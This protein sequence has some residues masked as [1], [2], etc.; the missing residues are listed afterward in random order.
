[1]ATAKIS[2]TLD[3]SLLAEAR[4]LVGP[5]GLS[6]YLNQALRLQLQHHRLRGL[7]DE[8]E[9]EHGPI[10]PGVMEEV[11]Q[12]WPDPERPGHHGS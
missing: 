9:K 3:E 8:L 12:T 10:D 7:L 6:S 2:L 11:R 1:M 5:R 4:E